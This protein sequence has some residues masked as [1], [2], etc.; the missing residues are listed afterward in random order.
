MIRRDEG[1]IAAAGVLLEKG[2]DVALRV[3]DVVVGAG[4]SVGG[5]VEREADFGAIR[6]EN[7][8]ELAA[9]GLDFTDHRAVRVENEGSRFPGDGFRSPHPVHVV[10]V[11]G[12][13]GGGVGD[14]G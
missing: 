3:E 4:Q 1:A 8:E 7:V 13:V 6:A 9:V 12:R 2:G 10:G 14:A 11:G 5:V